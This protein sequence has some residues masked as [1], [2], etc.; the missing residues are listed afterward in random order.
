MPLLTRAE[1]KSLDGPT[2]RALRV[3]RRKEAEEET[4]PVV[5][6]TALEAATE[7][8]IIEW[9]DD[10]IAGKK[11]M[12]EVV[13]DLAH[14]VDEWLTWQRYGWLGPILEKL[15]G[16]ALRLLIGLVRAMLRPHVQRVF[17]R[18]RGEGRV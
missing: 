15:D 2:K 3:E 4:E 6:E 1:R 17:D 16:L 12:N 9:M 18:L 5:D 8:R 14:N 7:T 13:D 11:K 10:D